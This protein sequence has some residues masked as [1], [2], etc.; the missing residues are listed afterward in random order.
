[1]TLAGAALLGFGVVS[2]SVLM[3]VGLCRAV[4]RRYRDRSGVVLEGRRAVRASILVFLIGAGELAITLVLY[5][6]TR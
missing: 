2:S 1:M 4:T 3:G 6:A 5:A